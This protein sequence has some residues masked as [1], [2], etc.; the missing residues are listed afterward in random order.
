MKHII[1][2]ITN[3]LNNKIYIG[4]HSTEDINDS[5]MGSG[6]L[7]KAAQR[8]Y[9]MEYFTK[10]ILHVLHSS[11]EMYEKEKEIVDL[12]F[13]KRHDTYNISLGGKGGLKISNIKN[14]YTLKRIENYQNYI[15]ERERK[16]AESNRKRSETIK[17]MYK[18]SAFDRTGLKLSEAHK[19]KISR[20]VSVDGV[21]YSSG[22]EAAN[23]L[24]LS[25]S[26]FDY[27]LKS[28]K[29]P[30]WKLVA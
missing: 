9:G 26:G 22:T 8:K 12:D 28:D 5:Y 10:E 30:E 4:A 20:P 29:F 23:A 25:R 18:G 16:K 3:T 14:P 19:A 2:K 6:D 21:I 24:G 27:I 13:I 15:N 1:Y 17:S 11:E 7:I